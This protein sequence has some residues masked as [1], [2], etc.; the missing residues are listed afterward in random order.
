MSK[1]SDRRP[2][3]VSQRDFAA[4]WDDVF[5][6]SPWGNNG[7]T[8]EMT[9]DEAVELYPPRRKANVRKKESK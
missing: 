3:Q 8:E 7:M 5:K 2:Q 4:R 6:H 1:G 9:V